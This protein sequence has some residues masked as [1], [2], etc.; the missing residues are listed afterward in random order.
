M[1]R[2]RDRH[3]RYFVDDKGRM[4]WING[5]ETFCHLSE[6]RQWRVELSFA[7]ALEWKQCVPSCLVSQRFGFII[8]TC[9]ALEHSE[10]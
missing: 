3:E 8:E 7:G 5:P 6:Y 1:V 10:W 2:I 9:D 4:F